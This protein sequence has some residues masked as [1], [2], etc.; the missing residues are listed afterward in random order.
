MRCP[1]PSQ[2][3]FGRIAAALTDGGENMTTPGNMTTPSNNVTLV[4][5][6]SG[7]RASGDLGN[8]GDEDGRIAF[9]MQSA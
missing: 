3:P 6:S 5:G 2:V 7:A 8:K 9:D 1:T 4:V